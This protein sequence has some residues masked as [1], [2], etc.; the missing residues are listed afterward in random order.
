MKS[1]LERGVVSAVTK[2]KRDKSRAAAAERKAA[3]TLRAKLPKTFE[4][5][6]RLIFPTIV[7]GAFTIEKD[8]R[9]IRFKVKGVQFVI[10]KGIVPK[11]TGTPTE[12]YMGH[13]AY[14][15]WFLYV[16]PKNE[17]RHQLGYI[18]DVSD[19]LIADRNLDAD[20]KKWFKEEVKAMSDSIAICIKDFIT[21]RDNYS[22]RENL[23]R[24]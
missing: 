20:H 11:D 7:D 9:E 2:A 13:A 4:A 8:D 5:R 6:V 21:N 10:A 1:T 22:Y 19:N 14:W 16:E 12:G 17:Y 18:G 24:N 15:S 3:A 23:R